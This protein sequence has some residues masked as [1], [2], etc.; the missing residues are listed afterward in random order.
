MNR[1]SV[2]LL[3]ATVVALVGAL[4]VFLYVRSADSR[5]QAQYDTVKVL[6]VVAQ[7][8]PGETID[9]A[10]GSGKLKLESVPVKDV[11][12]GALDSIE[13]LKGSVAITTIYIGEQV[14][15]DKFG[16]NVE[17]SALAI[18]KGMQAISVELT[19]PDRVAGFVSPGSFVALYHLPAV[20]D[21]GTGGGGAAGQ[22]R[23]Q[24][25]LKKVLVL[26]VGSTST[27]TK[28]T[29]VGADGA[30]TTSETPQ[31]VLT[32]AV[33]QEDAEKILFVEDEVVDHGE[34]A[35]ALISEDTD[36]SYGKG[37]GWDNLYN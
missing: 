28:K 2:L 17:T 14:L 29:T 34:V 15:P 3:L 23:V 27:T 36:L 7:I 19:D 25:L 16:T 24:L 5:A 1:R 12:P 20:T 33:S 22:D 11:V 21:G 26:G 4:L 8:E 10:A 13:S 9:A 30:Q 18:P 32:L 37:T 6:K 31:T 35:F